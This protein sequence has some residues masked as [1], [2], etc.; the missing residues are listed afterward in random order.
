MPQIAKR[1][2]EDKAVWVTGESSGIGKAIAQDF[3]KLEAKVLLIARS[4]ENLLQAVQE[5]ADN[6]PRIAYL[7]LD[8]SKSDISDKIIYAASRP[9]HVNIVHIESYPMHQ[10]STTT[11]YGENNL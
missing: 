7:K 11:A 2:F 1:L 6:R 4:E 10:A 8:V 3:A 5:F 9:P